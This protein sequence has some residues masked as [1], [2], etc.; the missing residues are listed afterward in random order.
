MAHTS[1]TTFLISGLVLLL[2]GGF[3]LSP[4]GESPLVGIVYSVQGNDAFRAG[5]YGDAEVYFRKALNEK[6]AV[7]NIHYNLGNALYQQ[8]RYVE[9]SQQFKLTLHSGPPAL[10]AQAWA[11][12]ANAYYQSGDLVGSYAAYRKALLLCPRDSSIR[13]DF[14][15]IM[16]LLAAKRKRTE[17]GRKAPPAHEDE[18]KKAETSGG[19]EEPKDNAP[20]GPDGPEQKLSDK[21]MEEIFGLINENENKAR[22]VMN[23]A[24]SKANKPASDEK[25]Y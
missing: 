1:K 10:Q 3:L 17:Q 7:S 18:G 25:D 11:N 19:N 23:G 21:N 6:V 12:M 2:A 14:L 13:Q 22:N 16:R 5:E 9:A 15:F 24:R 20:P 4:G 8:G